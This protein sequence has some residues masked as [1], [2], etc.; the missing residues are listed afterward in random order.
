M[1]LMERLDR[2]STAALRT[3][4]GA[5]ATN[6]AKVL[7][8]WRIAAGPA[9][10]RAAQTSWSSEDG[11]LRVA[12]RTAAWQSE[13][14]RA[15]PVIAARFDELLGPGVVKRWEIVRADAD[16]RSDATLFS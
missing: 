12:A 9:M 7:F 15:R 16:A 4:L 1:H 8:V 6:E 10:A 13:V 2:T 11:T 14:R 3:L 5:Q